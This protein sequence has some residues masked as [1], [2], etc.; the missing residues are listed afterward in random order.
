MFKLSF[1]NKTPNNA[2][3]KGSTNANVTAVDEE[4][5]IRPL[6]KSK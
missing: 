1:N 4:T 5:W 2:A 3:V 6:E